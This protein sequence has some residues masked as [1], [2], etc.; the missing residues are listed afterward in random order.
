MEKNVRL[1]LTENEKIA[2]SVVGLESDGT[3]MNMADNQSIEEMIEREKA[4]KTGDH[5][6]ETDK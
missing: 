2:Q 1:D 3:R 6:K 4:A 5:K